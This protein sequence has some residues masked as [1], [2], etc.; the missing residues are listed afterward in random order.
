MKRIMLEWLICPRCQNRF[1]LVAKHQE[2]DEVESG[3]LHCQKC[4][5]AYPIIRGI[6]R[7]VPTENYAASFGYQ[8]NRYA[9]LQLDSQNGTTFSRQRF[10]SI[11][12]WKPEELA[13]KLVLDVGCGSGRFS[14]VVLA[15]GGE[16]VAMDLSSAVDAA[17]S[18]L[19]HHPKLHC[20]QASIYELPFRA[21][22]FD[23]VYCIGVIQH[24]PD[25]HRSV[26]CI[27]RMVRTGGNVGLWIYELT[28]KSLVG[29][30]AFKYGL[31]PWTKRMSIHTLERFCHRIERLCWP[32]LR[33]ARHRGTSGKVLMRLL[34]AASAHLQGIPLSDQDFR[35]WVR[36][37]TFDI[38]SPA[39]DHPQKFSKVKGWLE[40]AGFRVDPRHPHGAIS[41]TA[42]RLP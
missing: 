21:E 37:D 8:W 31:R 13:G 36:L 14:E 26:R 10:Y 27:S 11:T 23:Y 19:G 42:T 33:W 2:R 17:R 24:T 38:Y 12:E 15:A 30:T 5:A 35:E 28:W 6:A 18:N 9:R 4:A 39:H 25:P 1:D 29:T 3:S 7:F 32:I 22:L 20:V 40:N 34:P 41:I 16:V